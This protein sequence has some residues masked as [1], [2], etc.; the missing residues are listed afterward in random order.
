MSGLESAVSLRRQYLVALRVLVVLSVV[1][2][3]FA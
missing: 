3:L 1:A 2:V